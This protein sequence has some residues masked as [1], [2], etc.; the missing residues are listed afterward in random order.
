MKYIKGT[1]EIDS[2]SSVSFLA[3][4]NQINVFANIEWEYTGVTNYRCTNCLR[5]AIKQTILQK[6]INYILLN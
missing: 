6:P 4:Y 5:Q 1:I 2:Y 3:W